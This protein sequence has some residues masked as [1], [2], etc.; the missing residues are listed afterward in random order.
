MPAPAYHVATQIQP[1][2]QFKVPAEANT[3]KTQSDIE[4]KTWRSRFQPRGL[5]PPSWGSVANCGISLTSSR[6]HSR[7]SSRQYPFVVQT[8]GDQHR[9]TERIS[10]ACA[11]YWALE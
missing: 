10:P 8:R 11:R 4:A 9:R 2:S 1:R 3:A 5:A 7:T 6:S